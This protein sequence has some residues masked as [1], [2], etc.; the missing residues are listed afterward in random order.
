M[1]TLLLLAGSLFVC[2]SIIAAD[3]DAKAEVKAA[4]R[5]LADQE[6]YS[7]TATPKVGGGSNFRP[8]PTEGQTEKG[9]FTVLH[10][11]FGERTIE[12]AMK[13][14]KAALKGQDDWQNVDEL[15]GN[16]AFMA[17]RFKTYKA[18]AE[19][20]Q[21]LADKAKSLQKADDAY[22]GELTE[23]GAKEYLAFGRA[24][25]NPKDAKGSV[26]FWLKDGALSKYE[27]H[28]EGKV[29][30]RE[31]QEIEV[32]R[33]TTVEIKNVGSTKVSVPEEAKK[34]LS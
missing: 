11:T 21:G 5:K 30:G 20:A 22:V 15:E 9:G 12:A 27:Y 18:P 33:T 34:K 3:A 14:G 19:E 1:K 31:D 26:K 8:G 4:A 2:G 16:R 10:M 23:D 7:W 32:D 17:R 25:A 28:V 29:T 24:N 13:G 6:N